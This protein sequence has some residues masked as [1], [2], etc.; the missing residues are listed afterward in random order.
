[1]LAIWL[2][3]FEK[4]W[5]EWASLGGDVL[6][7]A[8]SI[9]VAVLARGATSATCSGLFVGGE[10]A[11]VGMGTEQQACK[12]QKVVFATGIC[13]SLMFFVTFLLFAAL[14]KG[15]MEKEPGKGIKE[16]EVGRDYDVEK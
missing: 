2:Y 12:L 8:G 14:K 5:V 4:G 11:Q 7:I 13:N 10:E 1:M 3:L 15:L 6:A 9:A 16:E